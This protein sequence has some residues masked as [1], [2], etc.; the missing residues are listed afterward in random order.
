MGRREMGRIATLFTAALRE[1][2]EPHDIRGKVQGLVA[3]FPP[4]AG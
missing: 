4:F 1:Q 3:G 2:G